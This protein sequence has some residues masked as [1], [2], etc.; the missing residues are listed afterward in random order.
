MA[1]DMIAG[2]VQGPMQAELNKKLGELI[3]SDKTS[4]TVLAMAMTLRCIGWNGRIVI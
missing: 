4:H 3:S 1:T 2:V